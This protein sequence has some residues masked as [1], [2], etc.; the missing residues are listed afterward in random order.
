[1][2]R[3][4][5]LLKRDHP[6]YDDA[7]RAVETINDAIPPGAPYA[8]LLREILKYGSNGTMLRLNIQWKGK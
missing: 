5:T 7:A 8:D 3:A 6:L 2:Y 4:I 1:M